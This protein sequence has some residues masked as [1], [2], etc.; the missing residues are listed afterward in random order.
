MFFDWGMGFGGREG[1]NYVNRSC[2][3]F[4]MKVGIRILIKGEDKEAEL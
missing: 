4:R 3:D 2:G 1:V